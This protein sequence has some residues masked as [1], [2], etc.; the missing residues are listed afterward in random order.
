M[1][2][3]AQFV[4]IF[5]SIFVISVIL[6]ILA[7]ESNTVSNNMNQGAIKNSY[8]F[9]NSIF[10]ELSYQNN[11]LSS[12][13]PSPQSAN[14]FLNT[15]NTI[16][17]NFAK[18][19]SV[20]LSCGVVVSNQYLVFSNT[21]PSLQTCVEINIINTQNIPTASP[22]QQL[23]IVNSSAYS[24]YEAPNLDNVEFFFQ[25]GTI[26]PSW[27]ESGNSNTAQQ[28]Y[29]WIKLGSIPADSIIKI[30]MG[31]APTDVNV[32]N[33]R[34]TGEAPTL[35]PSYGEYDDGANVFDYYFPGGSDAG[36]TLSGAAGYTT[37]APS[38]SPFG[39]NALYADGSVGDYMYIPLPGF[40]ATGNYII[41]Y[42]VNVGS[43]G[44]FFFTASPS[45]A[46]TMT[47]LD[48]R[49]GSNYVGLA[50]TASWTSWNAPKTS[51]TASENV[52]YLQT[53]VIAGGGSSVG[54]YISSGSTT[55][56]N[57]G[58][59][60]NP[61]STTYTDSGGT[62]TYTHDGTYIGLIGD[63]GG[64][65]SYWNGIIVRAYPPYGVMPTTSFLFSV[66][67]VFG[68]IIISNGGSSSTT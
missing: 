62:E 14:M 18:D 1:Q 41:Q 15:V 38:G 12:F 61:L 30:Y 51:T 11:L 56:N 24:Q 20:N 35:S 17:R 32:L 5:F 55:Y 42:Y 37:S 28:T 34:T 67:S 6:S 39:T 25:N 16:F 49:G 45:G 27:M 4:T 8:Y 40:D 68:N 26:I 2:K 58:L 33:N 57:L 52:W 21:P 46:G 63:G 10:Q 23:L 48:G 43:L 9:G 29:Y 36:W 31:F 7:L 44:D 64:G 66:H 19:Y 22:F 13:N 65:V 50:K 53:T 60:V 47:R 59:T 54:D 3:K